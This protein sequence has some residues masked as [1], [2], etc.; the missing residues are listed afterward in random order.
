MGVAM[1]MSPTQLGR[2]IIVFPVTPYTHETV[3]P[4][5]VVALPR[6]CH[7]RINPGDLGCDPLLPE[8]PLLVVALIDLGYDPLVFGNA[9]ITVDE[10]AERILGLIDEQVHII[11][12]VHA[13]FVREVIELSHLLEIDRPL[14][15]SDLIGLRAYEGE[16]KGPPEPAGLHPGEKLY[17][18]D[19][20]SVV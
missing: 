8:T 18:L 13:R 15:F 20:K 11:P 16:E 5:P 2:Y 3:V 17:G 4:H 19:R 9:R 1:T 12:E 6:L 14:F 7:A 10:G